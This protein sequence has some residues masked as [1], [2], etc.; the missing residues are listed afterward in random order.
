MS[1]RYGVNKVVLIT[2][3]CTG[4]SLFQIV[5]LVHGYEEDKV[6]S[7]R[8]SSADVSI[9]VEIDVKDEQAC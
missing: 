4:R 3:V 5:I 1:E 2:Y 6:I 8:W 9:V 7:E